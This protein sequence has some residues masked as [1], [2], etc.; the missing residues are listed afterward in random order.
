M[1]TL[2]RLIRI[3]ELI[4]EHAQN[5]PEIDPLTHKEEQYK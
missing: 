2:T 4:L 1:T 5:M 3:L